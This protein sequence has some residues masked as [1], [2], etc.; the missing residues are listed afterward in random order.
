MKHL[1]RNCVLHRDIKLRNILI[2][3]DIVKLSDF[4]FAKY[5]GSKLAVESRQCGTPATMAPEVLFASRKR[6]IVYNRKSDIWSLGV[7]LHEL[8]Y[9]CHPFDYDSERTERCKR[10]RVKRPIEKI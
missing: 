6:K 5:L 8:V 7:I 1:S 2:K 4:G 3:D 9:D 10:V